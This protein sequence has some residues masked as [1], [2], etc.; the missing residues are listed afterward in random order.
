MYIDLDFDS[1]DN[2]SLPSMD[3]NSMLFLGGDG[4][5]DDLL[6]EFE[7]DGEF[8]DYIPGGSVVFIC[9]KSI[10]DLLCVKLTW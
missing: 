3:S 4:D 6:P 10:I 7:D 5:D 9:S 1:V 2:L 8:D